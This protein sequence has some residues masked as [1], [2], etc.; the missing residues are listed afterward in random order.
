MDDDGSDSGVGSRNEGKDEGAERD[1]KLSE[2]YYCSDSSYLMCLSSCSSE[3]DDLRK[4]R[5]KILLNHYYADDDAKSGKGMEEV[6]VR[7]ERMSR[8]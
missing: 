4:R 2:K 6:V 8:K 5:R 7:P 3:G 1:L